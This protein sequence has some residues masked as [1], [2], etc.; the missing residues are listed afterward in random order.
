MYSNAEDS[1]CLRLPFGI[2]ASGQKRQVFMFSY[3]K[4]EIFLDSVKP[5]IERGSIS[6]INK[7]E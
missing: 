6:K 2:L 4:L 7:F 5:D 1:S 3:A